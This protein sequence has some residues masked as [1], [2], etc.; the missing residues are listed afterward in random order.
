MITTSIDANFEYVVA[1]AAHFCLNLEAAHEVGQR[2][3]SETLE[4]AQEN[5]KTPELR[6]FEDGDGNRFVRFDALPGT[7]QVRY[8]AEVEHV[9]CANPATC[10]EWPITQL[11]DDVLTYVRSS[12]YCESDLLS[13]PAQDLFGNEPRGPQRI[14]RIMQW[15]RANIRYELGSSDASTSA[16]EVYD[17]R[18]G[19]CRD[20]AHLCIAFCRALN[21]PARLVVGY[22][23]FEEPPQDFHAIFEAWLGEWVR[24]DPTALALPERLVRVGIGS[25]AKD[26][27]FATIYGP[28]RMHAMHFRM[29]EYDRK[30]GWHRDADDSTSVLGSPM[31]SA[32]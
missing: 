19:V 32:D 8:R 9:T 18:A 23:L 4:V 30:A 11:P 16:R 1:G 28:V 31:S 10:A 24:F 29:A 7:L 13:Q 17:R 25:D 5:S 22:V 26:V 15:V 21:I 2:V 6:R 12:R 14:E 3:V 27:A 20:Y